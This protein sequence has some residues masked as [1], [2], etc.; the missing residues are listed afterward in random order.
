MLP[1]IDRIEEKKENAKRIDPRAVRTRQL[2][3][4]AFHS[5]LT[6]KSFEEITV[7]D[8]AERATVNRATFY[9]HFADKY[10]LGDTMMREGF[11]SMMEKRL[12]AGIPTPQ[13]YV[14]SLFLAVTDHWAALNG[15]CKQSYRM[16]ESLMESQIKRLLFENI[17]SWLARRRTANSQQDME[18]IATIVSSSIYGAAMQW[19]K[20]YRTESAESFVDKAVPVITASLL[21]LE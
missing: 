8:I 21:A 16:F 17:S 1:T 20:V 7:Q 18:M 19:T 14:R 15:G 6:E 9:A 11:T 13:A 2:L 10:A 5:M 12:A 4:D 3:F